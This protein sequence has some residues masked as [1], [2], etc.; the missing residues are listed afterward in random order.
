M[1]KA[2]FEK[3]IKTKTI[4][5]PSDEELFSLEGQKEIEME[6][7]NM[8][9]YAERKVNTYIATINFMRFEKKMSHFLDSKSVGFKKIKEEMQKSKEGYFFYRN[10]F[11]G[12]RK[13]SIVNQVTDNDDLAQLILDK[14]GNEG[15]QKW[16]RH[17]FIVRG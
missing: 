13:Y 14:F 2:R 6:L 3:R 10:I 12:A 16:I 17:G 1:K 11:V 15:M 8:K 7:R 4:K 5:E 9:C